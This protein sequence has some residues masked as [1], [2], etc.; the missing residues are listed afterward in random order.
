MWQFL[1][2]NKAPLLSLQWQHWM[3]VSLG[4]LYL[5]HQIC[6]FLV[7]C[8]L[9]TFFKAK[10]IVF[11]PQWMREIVYVTPVWVVEHD[12]KVG[13]KP[14][15]EQQQSDA[16]DGLEQPGF[17]PDLI[18][19]SVGCFGKVQ[20]FY[21]FNTD[22][23]AF[24]YLSHFLCDGLSGHPCPSLCLSS[25]RTNNQKIL[26]CALIGYWNMTVHSKKPY[27]SSTLGRHLYFP[28][29]VAAHDEIVIRKVKPSMQELISSVSGIW[30]NSFERCSFSLLLCILNVTG[31]Y[32]FR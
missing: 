16:S 14:T 30:T 3:A 20:I 29:P 2:Q 6:F 5:L 28:M 32:Q 4:I 27:T 17:L 10:C 26:Q 7:S 24:F 11:T 9:R 12:T 18:P 31:Q 21:R 1:P 13:T 8:W 22:I 19:I 23:M 25:S 15:S